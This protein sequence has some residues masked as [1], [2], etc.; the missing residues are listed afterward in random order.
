VVE[1]TLCKNHQLLALDLMDC[2]CCENTILTFEQELFDGKQENA[3]S[4]HLYQRITNRLKMCAGV[5]LLACSN[6]KQKCPNGN[7]R[8]F[9]MGT[10]K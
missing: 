4:L 5:K 3:N 1:I 2:S 8:Q 7:W 9:P 6:R 10:Q